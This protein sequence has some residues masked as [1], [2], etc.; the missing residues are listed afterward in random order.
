MVTEL[1]MTAAIKVID[2]EERCVQRQADKV[3]TE[4]GAWS[5]HIAHDNGLSAYVAQSR[6]SRLADF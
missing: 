4:N 5:G 3:Q 1:V 2:R 6:T